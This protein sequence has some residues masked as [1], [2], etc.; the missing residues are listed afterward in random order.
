M[1]KITA[2]ILALILIIST[3]PFSVSAASGEFT[4]ADGLYTYK[5]FDSTE[6]SI[7]LIKYLGADETVNV[8]GKVD[9]KPVVEIGNQCFYMN[10][11][12]KEIHFPASVSHINVGAFYA[13]IACEYYRVD[14][15]NKNY[16][17]VDGVIYD[18]SGTKLCFCPENYQTETFVIKD[19]VVE[20]D[21]YA[22]RYHQI[23]YPQQL[24]TYPKIKHIVF[25]EG[26]K[27][28]R[29]NAFVGSGIKE[30]I[31]PDSL[32]D[33][34]GNFLLT[35]DS[36][37]KLHIGANMGAKFTSGFNCNSLKEISVSPD[38]ETF[39]VENN[40]LYSK[41][42]TTMYCFPSGRSEKTYRIPNGVKT[43][44]P[45]S[46][47]ASN[48]NNID[49][50]EVETISPCTFTDLIIP[51]L[52]LPK[53]VKTAKS[54]A[55]FVQPGISTITILNPE[56]E[57]SLPFDFCGG[58]VNYNITMYGFSGSTAEAYVKNNKL[59]NLKI[60][61]SALHTSDTDYN[62]TSGNHDYKGT[63]VAPTCLEQ[64]YTQYKCGVCGIEYKDDYTDA[65]GHNMQPYGII[66]SGCEEQGYTIY[67]CSRC[68]ETTHGNY[69]PPTGH[70]MTVVEKAEATCTENGYIKY[71][72]LICK[73]TK[74]DIIETSGHSY[75]FKS[76]TNPTCTSSGYTTLVCDECSDIY[77]TD[78]I[79]PLG[80][81]YFTTVTPATFINN[82]EKTVKCSRCKKTKSKKVIN[83]IA[84]VRL[85]CSSLVYSGKSIKTPTVIAKDTSNNA[86]G[87][88][89]YT[90]KIYSR[91]NNKSVTNLKNVGQYKA[92]V[93]FN[94]FYS[95]DKTLYF[96]IKP[97][98][99]VPVSAKPSKGK[100][101]LT[102]KK[103][104]SVSG[105][106]IIVSE[107]KGFIKKVKTY[108]LASTNKTK[109]IKN[110]K[111][112]KKYYIKIRSY[113]TVIVDGKKTKM[114]SDY[115]KAITVKTK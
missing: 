16:R 103:D 75:S 72:C 36:Y 81:N 14:E 38:N 55:E 10:Q 68:D 76:K 5:Y 2:V 58:I 40:V 50:N 79:E 51:N 100:I 97:K 12:I 34:G 9:E 90:V 98:A 53:S 92:I 102:L 27:I 59:N 113:K 19:D 42:K 37:E 87:V 48:L 95:G 4:T 96:Y 8:P 80:H 114:Y 30:F 112:N 7:K 99:P 71:K 89:N 43:L 56:C 107:N 88:S 47:R 86:I 111:K 94:D 31:L 104:S 28:I 41:D 49:F 52:V 64:G 23:F 60:T 45:Y 35:T 93:S 83:K 13:C 1:K 24:Y 39:C 85:A 22:F 115:A 3:M 78:Y 20:I 17:S 6:S 32:T 21:S 25:P 65:L 105:Y 101:K 29:E 108:N 69:T 74:T 110:L 82:G 57:F 106:Q 44:A 109:T 70:N 11:S 15:N 84:S 66:P 91:A 63:V 54:I 62:I 33:E 73:K 77:N 46:F 61:F 26:L 18:K 67:K